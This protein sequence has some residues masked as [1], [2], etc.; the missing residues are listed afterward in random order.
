MLTLYFSGT[1]NTKYIAERFSHEMGA[2]CFS[3]ETEVNFTQELKAHDTVV[4][5]YPVYGSRVPR[6]MREFVARHM[7]DIN[8]KKIIILV[9]QA[10]FSGDG[11]RVF[12]DM[13]WD[14]AIE[15]IYAEHICMPNNVN[16]V[17]LLR[18]SNTSR[19]KKYVEKADNQIM[20]ICRDIRSGKVKKRGF[21][22]FSQFLGCLQGKAWQGNSKEIEPGKRT[23]ESWAK[24]RV[25]IRKEC[26]GCNI[27][28]SICP[29][30]NLSNEEHKIISGNN[31][32]VCY[33]CINRCPQKAISVMI[34]IKPRWQYTGVGSIESLNLEDYK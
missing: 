27:C 33:R 31:C 25:K 4:F 7:S 19:I 26:I 8:G 3:I 24:S 30:K 6:I 21:S 14:G 2:S 34:N 22:R 20:Q 12:T 5:C 1:G 32:I 15:V 11:A 17:P 23:A 28:I 10:L 9:T 18:K 29:M 13:F 16:N